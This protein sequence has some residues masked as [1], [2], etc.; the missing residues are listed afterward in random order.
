VWVCNISEGK[1]QNDTL[2]EKDSGDQLT[3]RFKI[4]ALPKS[5][6]QISEA[7]ATR[8]DGKPS[9]FVINKLEGM[10]MQR[11]HE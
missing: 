5:I 9:P 1:Y 7:R 11:Q 6:V 4:T 8:G 3:G 10:K 2:E